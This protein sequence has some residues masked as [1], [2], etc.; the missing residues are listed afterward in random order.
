MGLL[1]LEF[2]KKKGTQQKW[3]KEVHFG[4][5]TNAQKQ[6]IWFII[7]VNEDRSVGNI[8]IQHEYKWWPTSISC[9]D[10]LDVLI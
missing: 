5:N 7:R 1:E 9:F 3:F 4:I 6:N 8:F 10:I 2:K